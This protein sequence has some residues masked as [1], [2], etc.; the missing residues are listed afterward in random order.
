MILIKNKEVIA[1]AKRNRNL[2]TLDLAQLGK[3][4]TVINKEAMAIIKRGQPTYLVSQ[5]KR[6]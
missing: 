1:R 2:F 5:N 4:M 3:A 6:I